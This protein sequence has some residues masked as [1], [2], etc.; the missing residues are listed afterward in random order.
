[1]R[2]SLRRTIWVLCLQAVWAFI[3]WGQGTSGVFVGTVTDS[4]GAAVSGVRVSVVNTATGIEHEAVTDTNGNY[5]IPNVAPGP[6]RITAAPDGFKKAAIEGITL[7]VNQES[8]YDLRLE[9]GSLSD[10]VTVSA[11][12]TAQVQTEE[13]SLGQ[14]VNQKQVAD[15]PLNGRNFMELITLGAGAAPIRSS[16]GSAINGE[17]RRAGLSFSVSGQREVSTSYLIDGIES[18]SM[19]QQMIALQPS[20]DAIQEFK[21]QRNTFPAEFGGGPAVVNVAIKSGTNALHGSLYEFL[22]NDKLDSGQFQDPVVNGEKQKPPFRMNQFGFS[23]GGPVLV[24][25]LYDGRN[26]TFFFFNYEG[27]RRLRFQQYTASAIPSRFRSGDFSGLTDSSGVPI[28]IY[29]PATYNAATGS[30]QPFTGNV[31]PGSRLDPLSVKLL[32]FFPKPQ[33]EN[34]RYGDVNTVVASNQTRNDDQINMRFDHQVNQSL[35]V[36]GRYSSYDSPITDPLNYAASVSASIYLLKTHNLAI[37]ATKSFGPAMLNDFRFGIND[38]RFD[39][40][41]AWHGGN[42]TRQLGIQNLNPIER[43]WG[44]PQI[45]GTYFSTIGPDTGDVVSGGRMYQLTDVLTRIH[46]AH[47]FKAGATVRMMRPWRLAED[48]GR[49]GTYT[50]SGQFTAQLN[51]GSEVGGTGID[52]ADML[53][54]IPQNAQAAIGSTFTEFDWTDTHAFL[55]D[56]VKLARGLTLNLGLRYEYN[57]QPRPRDNKLAGWCA[58]CIQDGQPGK[59]ILTDKHEVRS[60]VVDPDWN[61]FA[62]RIGV[63][64]A[65]FQSG[66]TVIRGG[67]GMFYD[68]TKGDE[69]NFREFHPDKLQY[70]DVNNQNPSPTFFVKDSFPVTPVGFNSSPFVVNSNDRWPYVQQWN[71]NVQQRLFKNWL[72]EAAYV[73]SHAEHLS[74]RWNPN[75]AAPDADPSKPTDIS[76][77]LPFPRFGTMLGSYKAGKSNYNAL[78]LRAEKQFSRGVSLLTGYTWSHCLDTDSSSAF[79][80]DN[81]DIRN[82]QGDYGSCGFDARQRLNAAFSWAVPTPANWHGFAG[83]VAKGWQ[84][85]T[86]GQ[87]QSGSPLTPAR[88]GDPVR[89]GGF[90]RPR[91][92]RVCNGNLPS[93][94]RSITRYFDTNCFVDPG[95]GVFGNSGRNV[96][97]GPPLHTVDLSVFKTTRLT[98]GVSLQFRGEIFNA[99]NESNYNQPT[100]SKGFSFG[101]ILSEGDAREIQFGLKVLF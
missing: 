52:V 26:H 92:D 58:T 62:P 4:S 24:P 57:M 75:Q 64:W 78:Q 7:Q 5:Q 83:A 76:S 18:R 94:Q 32:N 91:F 61:N 31:I 89:V 101:K 22:R 33:N 86:I 21:L 6:Y 70:T 48:N 65:P 80:T 95:A 67:F 73:G 47:T 15:L 99:L 59:Q 29:D 74:K 97:V 37:G 11:S 19:F 44:P 12:G 66:A 9:V 36:F 35:S 96:I 8:R 85:N 100:S 45:S 84:L 77:R 88:R 82:L 72:V 90:Y 16:G 27:L 1:M 30:R 51:D 54:G 71:V 39:F 17:T 46:G 79:A 55:S 56:D 23:V 40:V 49:R 10:S 20:V 93:D 42:I 34:A 60:Q 13:A 68:N 3:A 50:F 81:Q 41:P 14:V 2:N 53:L 28:P 43:Q 38:D 25:K 87:F 98:E 63:A 69:L